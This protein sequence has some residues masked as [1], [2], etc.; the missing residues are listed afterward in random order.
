MPLLEGPYPS[1]WCALGAAT[2]SLWFHS[3]SPWSAVSTG[4]VAVRAKRYP[5]GSYLM[6]L[7]LEMFASQEQECTFESI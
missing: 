5:R 3:A 1:T 6:C 4:A 2:V 7:A